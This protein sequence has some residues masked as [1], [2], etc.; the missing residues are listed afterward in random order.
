VAKYTAPPPSSESS[1]EPEVKD[2]PSDSDLSSID[3][4]LEGGDSDDEKDGQRPASTQ[5]GAR[6]IEASG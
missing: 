4:D 1:D 5:N 6:L 2:E 3:A